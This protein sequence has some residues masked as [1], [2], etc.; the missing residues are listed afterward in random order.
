MKK[1]IDDPDSVVEDMV[2][3][4]VTAYPASFARIPGTFGFMR[5]NRPG[6]PRVA[7]VTGG[8]SGHEPL[9]SGYVGAGLADA[10][11]NGGIF[12]SPPPQA[13]AAV[14]KAADM[15]EG[16]L[17]IYG[18]YA[19]DNLNF[20][21]GG[22]FS[23]AQGVTTAYVRVWDDVASAPRERQFDRRG[24]AGDLFVIKCAG[25][26]ALRGW[27]LATV[28]GAT[29][30][31]RDNV[32]SIGVAIA[33][34]SHPQTGAPTFELPD[35]AMEFGMGL[36]GEPGVKRVARMGAHESVHVMLPYLVD[37]LH[38]CTGDSVV[39]L[40]NGLGSTTLLE[41]YV[42][43]KDIAEELHNRGINVRQTLVGSYSTCQEMAG[44]SIS[45]LKLDK[46]IEP[47]WNEPCHSPHISIGGE[48]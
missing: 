39:V 7:I 31:V 47:L 12:A 16:V 4:Y 42:V 8:G 22:E 18:N 20:D 23:E 43:N 32:A 36:H 28:K 6:S 19:G 33:P 37:D 14:N 3:G 13:I 2:E 46:D 35:D 15:G 26:A 30:H 9:F 25:A 5:K 27:D 24:I 1:L 48:F 45:F 17:N 21:M 29:E 11:V 10:C 34:G 44:I 38:L 41:Q 40:V